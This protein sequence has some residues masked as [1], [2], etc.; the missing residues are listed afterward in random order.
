MQPSFSTIR[1]QFVHFSSTY[2]KLSITQQIILLIKLQPNWTIHIKIWEPKLTIY[3]IILHSLYF[4][5]NHQWQH[6]TN[7]V[8]HIHYFRDSIVHFKFCNQIFVALNFF[9]TNPICLQ[10]K[11]DFHSCRLG[12][13]L[14]TWVLFFPCKHPPSWLLLI[15]G[16]STNTWV[17]LGTQTSCYQQLVIP[18]AE[19]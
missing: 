8:F 19:T 14:R 15:V 9:S 10:A 18:W 7:G 13:E 5:S 4:G 3:M 17:I 6:H 11:C 16:Y 1:S 12:S 2:Y